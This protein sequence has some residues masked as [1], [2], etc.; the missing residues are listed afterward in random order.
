MR[1]SECLRSERKCQSRES[2]GRIFKAIYFTILFLH[3]LFIIIKHNFCFAIDCKKHFFYLDKFSE[4]SVFCG[5][6][7]GRRNYWPKTLILLSLSPFHTVLWKLHAIVVDGGLGLVPENF[8]HR[9]I[10]R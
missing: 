6:K 8:S 3:K 7:E 4:N 2:I 1:V 10:F 5:L 9:N